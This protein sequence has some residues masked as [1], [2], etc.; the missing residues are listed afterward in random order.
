MDSKSGSEEEFFDC[1]GNYKFYYWL[2]AKIGVGFVSCLM[3]CCG[4]RMLVCPLKL[5][6]MVNTHKLAK[7][8]MLIVYSKI[9]PGMQFNVCLFWMRKINIL[10]KLTY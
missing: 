8:K 7:S 5:R 3:L 2:V 9:F 6:G 4:R 10:A 1:C